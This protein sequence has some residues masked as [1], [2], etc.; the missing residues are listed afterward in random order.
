MVLLTL[1]ELTLKLTYSITI[2]VYNSAYWLIYGTPKSEQDK[3][4]E[5]LQ[6]FKQKQHNDIT[7]LKK[8]IQLLTHQINKFTNNNKI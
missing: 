5:E 6:L 8:D 3:L 4:I 7:Q 1:T 2:G